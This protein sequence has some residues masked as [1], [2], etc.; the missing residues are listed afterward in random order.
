MNA[1]VGHLK[2]AQ[3][4]GTRHCDAVVIGAG[5]G[6]LY[7]LHKLRNEMGLETVAFDRAKDVGGTWYWNR[8]PGALS[9]SESMVYRYSFDRDLLDDWKWDTRYL[10]QPQVLDYLRHVADRYDLRRSI[11]FETGVAAAYYDEDRTIWLITT[12]DGEELTARFLVAAVGPLAATNMPDIKGLDTFGGETFHTSKW[13][14]KVELSGKRVGVIGTGST[15]IQL[16]TAIAPEVGQLTVFQ[17][18]PQYSVPVGNGPVSEEYLRELR[19]NYDQ[20]WED[21]RN[22]LFAMG[23]KESTLATM[24][25]S[26]EE[27]NAIFQKAWDHGGGF[28]YAFE[29]FADILVDPEANHAAASFIRGKIAEIVKDPETARKLMPTDYYVKRPLCDSGYYEQFNRDNVALVDLKANPIAEITPTGVRLADGTLHELDVLVFATGFDAVDGNFKKIDI[30]GRAGQSLADHWSGG[31]ASYLSVATAGFPNLFMIAGPL[32]PFSNFP[33]LLEIQVQLIADLVEHTQKIGS[34]SIEATAEAEEGWVQT[35][36][37]MASSMLLTKADSWM[38]GANIPG[39]PKRVLFY[40]AGIANFRTIVSDMMANG[41]SGFKT[42]KA[43]E[44]TAGR[45][46]L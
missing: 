29:T 35:C 30:K 8:Y 25:V 23:F 40:V 43:P 46:G 44:S 6:G 4:V 20:L 21:A 24:S 31:A 10:K 7:M 32:M 36:A 9:D 34:D 5:F 16:I 39:K 18:S 2:R 11:E 38:F 27:R 33:P 3:A 45:L 12:D 37:D 28:R 15:G 26:E 22:S 41:F 13:P 1:P 17:R 42:L 19:E 14:E